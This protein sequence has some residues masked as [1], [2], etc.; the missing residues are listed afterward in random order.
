MIA[1]VN[2]KTEPG[3]AAAI[4][5]PRFTGDDATAMPLKYLRLRF[6]KALSAIMLASMEKV[7]IFKSGIQMQNI[8]FNIGLRG[9]ANQGL[10]HAAERVGLSMA[11]LDLTEIQP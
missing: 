10:A 5:A 6:A 4:S 2:R 1:R 8:A 11:L 7:P 3:V 9:G